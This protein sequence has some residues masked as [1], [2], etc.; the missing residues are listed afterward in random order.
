MITA[1]L[2][3]ALVWLLV[4]TVLFAAVVRHLGALQ[5]AAGAGESPTGGFNFDT[6]G[7][8]I[9]SP[10][11]DRAAAALGRAGV[12]AADFV[13]V[14][15]S[16]G[17]G[18]CLERAHGIADLEPDRARTVFLIGG[19]HRPDPLADLLAALEPT[20]AP[21]LTD[22]D[23]HDIAKSLGIQ[24]TPF[25]FRVRDGQ[26]VGKVYVRSEADLE[27]LAASENGVDIT[28]VQPASA[29]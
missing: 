1:L 23:A 4:L 11:P 13:A 2:V 29:D 25:A 26:V 10:L 12:A 6:D 17:C 21:I 7:P 9:P 8:W 28:L 20:G 24:S 22:P 14:F 19:S 15:F 16:A 3:V 27:T 5:V 18:T